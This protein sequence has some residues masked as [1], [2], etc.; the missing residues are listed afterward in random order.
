MSHHKPL[1][2]PNHFNR[3]GE[4]VIIGNVLPLKL[5]AGISRI[6]FIFIT[7]LFLPGTVTAVPP[8]GMTV[9]TGQQ[10]VVAVDHS[11]TIRIVYGE[12]DRIYCVTST[13]DGGSFSNPE[14]IGK[15]SQMALGMQR[16][17]QIASS[18]HFTMVTAQD[19]E[20][21]IHT[22]LLNHKTGVWTETSRINDIKGSAPEGLMGIAA[23]DHDRFYA[24]WLDIRQNKRNNICF[25]SSGDQGKTWSANKMVYIS[26]DE[27]VCPCC[28]PNIAV[29]GKR[30]FI[31][32]R[33]WLNGSRDLYLLTSH[34]GGD[35]FGPAE[36]LGEGTWKINACPMDGGGLTVTKANN[37]YTVWQ[38]KGEIFYARPGKPENQVGMGRNCSISG[39]DKPVITWQDGRQLKMLV[40]MSGKYY[41]VGEGGFLKSVWTH[42]G[43]ILCTWENNSKIEISKI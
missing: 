16:G 43:K 11:G 18:R 31:M 19:K 42:D 35:T 4:S 29:S 36:K 22:Y 12:N 25:A 6:L 24:V 1:Y 34:D 37:V 8:G 27:H 15:V 39:K 40:L 13:D 32:F 30:V 17:P 2:S 26:P 23:D 14:F 3:A 21:E 33:N 41:D 9:A 5:F 38:R 10:P 7:L 20:G 28:K